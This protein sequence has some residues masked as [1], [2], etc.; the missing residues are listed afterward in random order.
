MDDVS[1]NFSNLSV[2]TNTFLSL[3]WLVKWHI[4]M[5]LYSRDCIALSSTCRQ[6]YDFNTFAYTHL[7]FLPPN[8]LFSLARSIQ[9]LSEVLARSPRYAEAVRTLRIVGWS[10]IDIPGS[11]DPHIVYR[12][13]DEGVSS[14]LEKAPHI[15]LLTLD[16][17]LTRAVHQFPQTFAALTRVRT[18]RHLRLA[19]FLTPTY[20]NPLLERIPIE[21][22]PAYER[23]SLRVCSGG[24]LPIVMQDPRKLRWFG[25][26]MLNEARSPGDTN[27]AV[28]LHRVA[29]AATELETLVLENG[30]HFDADSLGQ[31]LQFGFVRVFLAIPSAFRWLMTVYTTIG[32]WGSQKATL[33]FCKYEHPQ[34]VE[35]E[36]ALLWFPSFFDHA[37]EN[38]HQLLRNMARRNWSSVYP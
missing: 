21:T 38:H 4:Y 33:I 20:H 1:A 15:F 7:L 36:A 13:L 2:T 17:D 24:W 10:A 29:E 6:M 5:N 32:S 27:W 26:T 12:S 31:M 16:L 34:P 3:P 18:M 11:L 28:T 35:H 25:L 19:T 9:R 23:V 37:L 22:P 30:E 14:I 8:S